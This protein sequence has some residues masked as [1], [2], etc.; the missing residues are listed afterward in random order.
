MGLDTVELV[1]AV[2]DYFEITIPNE[3]AETLVTVGK[4]HEFVVSELT[5]TGRF[6]GDDLPG[7]FRTT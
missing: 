4:L 2:E 5:R 3:V 6:S 7:D 1:M